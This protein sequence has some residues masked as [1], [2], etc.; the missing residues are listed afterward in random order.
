MPYLLLLYDYVQDILERRAPHREEHLAAIH[1][2]HAAGR[3]LLAGAFGDP[4]VGAAFVFTGVDA[5]HVRAFAQED[6]YVRAELVRA[7]RVEP[8]NVVA[9]P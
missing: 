4:P 3:M 5:E 2:E 7:W 9:R 1:A 8:Y 6:P